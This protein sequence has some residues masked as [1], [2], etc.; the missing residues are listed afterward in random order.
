[1]LQLDD[2][3]SAQR[4]LQALYDEYNNQYKPIQNEIAQFINDNN[5][6]ISPTRTF[7]NFEFSS[8]PIPVII[9]RAIFQATLAQI[10]FIIENRRSNKVVCTAL[11]D[12]MHEVYIVDFSSVFLSWSDEEKEQILRTETK[13]NFN[14]N[15]FR[16]IIPDNSFTSFIGL[17]FACKIGFTHYAIA[18]IQE[19]NYEVK[20]FLGRA[21]VSKMLFT[22]FDVRARVC[23][24][25]GVIEAVITPPPQEVIR[26]VGSF[27]ELPG[28]SRTGSHT[29][30]NSLDEFVEM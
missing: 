13:G 21:S 4:K 28:I 23:D 20:T 19:V 3:G 29:S 30:T 22:E 9:S 27:Q 8:R 6:K 17:L 14:L 10:N 26:S 11:Y 16:E 18:E 5:L 25:L 2:V 15:K 24:P 12:R 7:W 1:M